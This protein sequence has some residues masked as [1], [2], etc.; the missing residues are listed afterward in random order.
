MTY[1]PDPP[2]V[3]INW[4]IRKSFKTSDELDKSLLDRA[5]ETLNAKDDLQDISSDE[6]R[7]SFNKK[8][9]SLKENSTPE[10]EEETV[11]R[12][13]HRQTESI[14]FKNETAT[15]EEMY[16]MYQKFDQL[17]KVPE[18]MAHRIEPKSKFEFASGT[19]RVGPNRAS[20]YV[21][22]R[23][24]GGLRHPVRI[25]WRT[26]DQTANA[27]K[28]YCA[29]EGHTDFLSGQ[30]IHRIKIDLKQQAEINNDVFFTI[31]IYK[32]EGIFWN[33]P[34]SSVGLGDYSEIKVVLINKMKFARLTNE[35]IRPPTGLKSYDDSASA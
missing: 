15:K 10:N 6:K 22:I 34:A 7:D 4:R 1:T 17:D 27:T 19:Y 12:E 21:D 16:K 28:H 3:I 33:L 25:F 18:E 13:S 2:Y 32:T 11:H 23:R 8:W 30:R 20:M 31:E 29:T 24:D 14:T 5:R 35:R 9:N 26:Q